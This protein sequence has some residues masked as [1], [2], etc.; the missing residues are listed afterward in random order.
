[1]DNATQTE[2]T[3][4]LVKELGWPDSTF[5]KPSNQ[6]WRFEKDNISRFLLE[7]WPNIDTNK[8]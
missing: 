6:T 3:V 7:M 2:S 8:T 1:M 5:L 4:Q